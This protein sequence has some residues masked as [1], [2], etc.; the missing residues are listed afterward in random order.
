VLVE[1]DFFSSVP[2]GSDVYVLKRVLH[3]WGESAASASCRVP[4]R[5]GS[6]R[7]AA[8]IEL[9]LPEWMTPSGP[10]LS[11]APA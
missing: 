4:R 11:A 1:G 3:D 10:M 5:D 6:G 9:L 7:A 8:I 2:A